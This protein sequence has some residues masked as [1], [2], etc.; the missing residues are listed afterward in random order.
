MRDANCV[1]HLLLM[2]YSLEGLAGQP[3]RSFFYQSIRAPD[4][5]TTRAH[6]A[7]SLFT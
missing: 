5:F 6:F 2:G 3:S 1:S 4:S 7:V